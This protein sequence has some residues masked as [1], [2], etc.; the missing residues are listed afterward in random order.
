MKITFTQKVILAG[1]GTISGWLPEIGGFISDN[2]LQKEPKQIIRQYNE[3]LNDSEFKSAYNLFSSTYQQQ[4]SFDNYRKQV[5]KWT[6]GIITS[7]PYYKSD[8]LC[9]LDVTMNAEMKNDNSTTPEKKKL[10]F[11][12]E[13]SFPTWEIT[14][15]KIIK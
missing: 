11:F 9:V 5:R 12:L 14:S 6:N 8:N 1:M 13:R 10:L 2:I 7:I 3:Y 15:I 4:K